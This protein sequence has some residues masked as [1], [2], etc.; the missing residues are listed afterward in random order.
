M[1]KLIFSMGTSLDGFIAG[2]D[3]DIGWGAPDAELHQF[4]NDRV[5][6]VGVQLCG[7]RLYEVMLYW[8]TPDPT[9][10]DIE[11]EFAEIWQAI[12]KLV[13]SRTLEEVQ[14]NARLV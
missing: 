6:E 5:R 2:P 1:R 3:G 13:F 14:G 4:H 11:R 7:R 9:W 12:P 10:G 8:E